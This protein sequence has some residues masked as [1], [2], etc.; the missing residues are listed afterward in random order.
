MEHHTTTSRAEAER[1]LG[2]SEKLLLKKDYSGCKDFAL[3]AQET[4]PLLEGSDQILAVAEVHLASARKIQNHHDWY[5]ILQIGG[6]TDDAEQIKKQYRRLALLLH[7]DKN[8]FEFAD[9]AFGLVADA[10]AVLSDPTKKALFDN[11]LSVY[12]KV[13]L[14]PKRKPAA[15][16][17][18]SAEAARGSEDAGHKLPVRRS[19]RVSNN[20]ENSNEGNEIHNNFTPNNINS[21]NNQSGGEKMNPRSVSSGARSQ[22]STFW[23]VCPYCYNLYEYERRYAGCCLRCENCEKAFT[24]AEIR[25]MPPRVPGKN[26][27]YC[28]WGFFPMGFVTGNTDVKKSISTSAA[29]VNGFPNW[30]PQMFP[31]GGGGGGGGAP[32]PTAAADGGSAATAAAPPTGGERFGAAGEG[33]ANVMGFAPPM[34]NPNP[35]PPPH[36]VSG[37][38]KKRGRP[39][40]NPL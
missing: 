38:P 13:D 34:H 9:A 21:G 31:G 28:C 33:N 8:K 29:A 26:A 23:S 20:N 27:Y 24:A 4:E 36:P 37:G 6:R 14:V 40:K 3:L 18:G 32:P 12:Q 30:M 11:E 1:L 22:R 35:P 2:V 16:Q 15:R 19:S 7:P 5:A 10:W 39:R 25:Q 17:P